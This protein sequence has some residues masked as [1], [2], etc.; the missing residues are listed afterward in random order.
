MQ[1]YITSAP[2]TC[3]LPQPI[4]RSPAYRVLRSFEISRSSKKNYLIT[5]LVDELNTEKGDIY[6]AYNVNDIKITPVVGLKVYKPSHTTGVGGSS[7]SNYTVADL[8]AL[9]KQYEFY[10]LPKSAGRQRAYLC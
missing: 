10:D 3:L 1:R 6:R 4:G 7:T 8:H 2:K 5:L 9:V